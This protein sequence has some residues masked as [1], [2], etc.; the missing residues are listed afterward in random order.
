MLASTLNE[1]PHNEVRKF[2]REM[3]HGDGAMVGEPRERF[4]N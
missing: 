3:I 1:V 2:A 4:I